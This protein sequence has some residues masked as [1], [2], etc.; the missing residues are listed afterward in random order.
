MTWSNGDVT[1]V[2]LVQSAKIPNPADDVDAEKKL[3]D[4]VVD[5]IQQA[6]IE[7]GE[8]V[9]K[10]YGFGSRRFGQGKPPGDQD[11]NDHQPA[12]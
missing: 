12:D 10:V 7:E 6:V 3:I 4:Q 9:P 8:L 2:P 5:A 1:S 11:A